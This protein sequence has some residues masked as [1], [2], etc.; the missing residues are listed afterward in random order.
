MYNN[1]KN[2]L[3]QTGHSIGESL[4]PTL[5]VS[6]IENGILTPEEFVKSGDQLIRTSPTWQW[7]SGHPECRRNYLPAD[8]QFLI[9]RSVPCIERIAE[10][11]FTE[12]NEWSISNT[13]SKEEIPTIPSDIES[14]SEDE[15]EDY[16]LISDTNI[17]QTRT[18]DIMITYDNYYRTP[19]M[20][21]YGYQFDGQ[22]LS[23]DD[24][25]S[26]IMQDYVNKTVTFESFPFYK[27]GM[28]YLSI[29]P[30]RHSE[31][32]KK[33]FNVQKPE[34]YLFLFL[35]FMQSVIPTIEYDFTKSFELN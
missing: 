1:I 30:C 2:K 32:M 31:V 35:K 7:T 29:H 27:S 16:Q 17:Q 4:L 15:Q 18:Y 9:T 22:P 11:E 19:R 28:L 20:W 21:L 14:E 13:F 33:L 24:M 6:S 12:D 25:M 3:V 10:I 26:D 5:K 23:R 34:Q 8:K